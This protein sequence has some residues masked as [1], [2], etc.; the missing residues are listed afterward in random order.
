[1][2]FFK[3]I[4]FLCF[5]YSLTSCEWGSNKFINEKDIS[6]FENE[7]VSGWYDFPFK[8]GLDS[9]EAFKGVSNKGS[10]GYYEQ[11]MEYTQFNGK[12]INVPN[13]S[14]VLG[15]NELLMTNHFNH[16]SDIVKWRMPKNKDIKNGYPIYLRNYDNRI[17]DQR[18]FFDLAKKPK[19]DL[20][21]LSL[22]IDPNDFFNYNS[23][24]YVQGA[25][26]DSSNV[27]MGNYAMR[28]KESEKQSFLHV[29]NSDGKLRFKTGAGIKLHGNLSR[30][31]PQKSFRLSLKKKF[32]AKP[33]ETSIFGSE[34]ILHHL[35]LRTPFTS[36]MQGQSI[37]SDS[38]ISEI[39][40]DLGLDAMKSKAC[41]VYLN[42]EYWGLYHLREKIDQYYFKEKYNVSKKSI[43]IVEFNREAEN[44]FIAT[45]GVKTEWVALLEYLKSNDISEQVH[46]E[47]ISNKIDLNN[48]IDYLLLETFFANKDWP[49]NNYKI[50]KSSDKDGKWRFIVYDTDASFRGDDMIRYILK[51][52]QKSGNNI[53]SSTLVFR[54]LFCNEQFKTLYLN[55][56]EKLKGNELKPSKLEK[57]L[58]K[59]YENIL[60][61]IN[62]QVE[63]WHMP[64]SSQVWED[65]IVKMKSYF[66]KR[67]SDYEKHLQGLTQK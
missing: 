27:K 47:Y 25:S 10:S 29:F 52:K 42:G 11:K 40:I 3:G 19:D 35:I 62:Y 36:A 16:K 33:I 8:L 30:A 39:A 56:F 23:G 20:M 46:F 1:M 15:V 54:K 4:I 66:K 55:R 49:G 28:G 13:P 48:L 60:P 32:G 17:W 65:R 38:F 43:D 53:S 22:T 9:G 50:W 67:S 41:H 18:V 7:P 6:L 14:S 37:I 64:E 59:F 51:E 34:Q 45:Q 2:S 57:R 63:R 21:I 12:I 26:I 58:Q 31:Q 5:F 61:S 44:N 24:I